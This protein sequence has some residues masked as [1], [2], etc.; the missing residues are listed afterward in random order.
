MFISLIKAYD[1]ILKIIDTLMVDVL[2]ITGNVLQ[3]NIVPLF[4]SEVASPPNKLSS[5]IGPTASPS[6]NVTA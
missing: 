5:T 2:L 1:V 4:N 6:P 3:F